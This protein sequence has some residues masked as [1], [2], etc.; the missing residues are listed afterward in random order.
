MEKLKAGSFGGPQIIKLINDSN[1]VHKMNAIVAAAWESF[2]SLIQQFL[3]NMIADNYKEIVKNYLDRFRL[4]G[5]NM[6]GNEKKNVS[7]RLI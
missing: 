2:A 4:L 1:C 7:I 6:T 5:C 3:G